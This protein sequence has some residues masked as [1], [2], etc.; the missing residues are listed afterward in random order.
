M[1]KN[2]N[3]IVSGCV[4]GDVATLQCLPAVFQN[5]VAAALIFV[6]VVAVFLIIISGF[7]FI[8]SG[9]DAKQV[10]GARNTMM[11][12]VIGLIIVL[13]SFFI[14]NIIGGITG[15]TCITMF[16]FQSCR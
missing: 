9:G 14:I 5:I 1:G 13:L 16:G 4:Q 3:E 6:G 8:L 15:A 7:K 12:A 10:E 2:W 11:Y